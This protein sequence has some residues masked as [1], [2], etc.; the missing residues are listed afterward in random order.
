[1]YIYVIYNIY[2][3]YIYN[4]YDNQAVDIHHVFSYFRS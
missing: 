1:M 3:I 2:D 4:I